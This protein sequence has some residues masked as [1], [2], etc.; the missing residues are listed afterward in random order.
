MDSEIMMSGSGFQ[1]LLM[2][3]LV[4]SISVFFFF[5][6]RKISLRI[7]SQ[8]MLLSGILKRETVPVSTADEG[9]DIERGDFSAGDTRDFAKD[10]IYDTV[11]SG[12]NIQSTHFRVDITEDKEIT[13]DIDSDDESSRSSVSNTVNSNDHQNE[14]CSESASSIDN[15]ETL[16]ELS[17]KELKA[18]LQERGLT[19]SGN[20]TSMIKRILESLN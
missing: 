16:T 2:F 12:D 5:E 10:S 17:V 1:L 15:E 18:I 4:I 14:T 9:Y 13:E 7:T 20:K 19:V 3:I 6:I 8:E 11:L